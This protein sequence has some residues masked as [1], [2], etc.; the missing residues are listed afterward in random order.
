MFVTDTTPMTRTASEEAQPIW[1][2]TD[3]QL[4]IN[5]HATAFRYNI[6]VPNG[7]YT[8]RLHFAELF[9]NAAGVR[10]FNVAIQGAAALSSFDIYSQA[11][12]AALIT[13]SFTT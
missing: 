4:Y 1:N 12:K 6:P 2:T 10:R 5:E 13:K 11:G 9:F 3:D 8:V 7:S